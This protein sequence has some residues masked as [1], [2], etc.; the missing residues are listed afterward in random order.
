M[1]TEQI[2]CSSFERIESF[3]SLVAS[4]SLLSLVLLTF[5]DVL[6]RNFLNSPIP[7]ATE[8]SEIALA[9][10]IFFGFPGLALRK[11]HIMVDLLDR[12]TSDRWK[13]GQ[14]IAGSIL[15][16]L[17]FGGLAIAMGQLANQVHQAGDATLQL[18]IPLAL[19]LYVLT[20][21]SAVTA[22]AF[23]AILRFIPAKEFASC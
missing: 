19:V 5:C 12:F 8:L 4:F 16:A 18:S 2:H 17:T 1:L 13:K 11:A 23:V 7:G 10:I 21:L 22:V 14:S 20:A 15:G 3:F 6:C 9:F